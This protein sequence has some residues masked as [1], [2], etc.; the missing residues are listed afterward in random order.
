MAVV[1]DLRSPP[2]RTTSGQSRLLWTYRTTNLP[3][4]QLLSTGLAAAA[5]YVVADCTEHT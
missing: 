5:K 1:F 2:R 4:G 3:F